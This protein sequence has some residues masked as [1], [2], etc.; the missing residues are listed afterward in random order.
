MIF[1]PSICSFIC[2]YLPEIGFFRFF[3]HTFHQ[4]K[5]SLWL[6][7]T[8]LFVLSNAWVILLIYAT[9]KQIRLNNVGSSFHLSCPGMSQNGLQPSFPLLTRGA[10]VLPGEDKVDAGQIL[11]M[12]LILVPLLRFI[13]ISFGPQYTSTRSLIKVDYLIQFPSSSLY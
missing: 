4:K 1:L 9:E 2:L 11:T 5:S 3:A 10:Q 13:L 8:V 7:L 12:A 6:G